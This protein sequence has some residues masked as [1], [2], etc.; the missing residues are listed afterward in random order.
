M[1]ITMRR[2]LLLIRCLLGAVSLAMAAGDAASSTQRTMSGEELAGLLETSL[3]N[4]WKVQDGTLTVEFERNLPAI[5]LP[6]GE[7]ALRW[8]TQI[9]QPNRRI[10]PQFE[11]R[12]DDQVAAMM[13]REGITLSRRTVAKYRDLMG[14]L[15]ARMRRKF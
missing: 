1:P 15:P 13:N 7:P 11:I 8:T 4:L 2:L 6:A 12:I 10:Y 3:R 5:S 14:I 9:Q